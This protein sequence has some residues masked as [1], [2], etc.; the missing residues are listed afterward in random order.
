MTQ[1]RTEK[2]MFPIV[3]E[4]FASTAGYLLVIFNS[5]R[6]NLIGVVSVASIDIMPYTVCPGSIFLPDKLYW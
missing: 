5:L 6:T 4:C 1:I 2:E 3:G